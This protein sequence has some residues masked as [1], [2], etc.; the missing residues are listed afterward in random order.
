[1][2]TGS[3]LLFGAFLGGSGAFVALF[4]LDLCGGLLKAAYRKVRSMSA[5]AAF[6]PSAPWLAAH[7]G[8][9]LR[10]AVRDMRRVHRGSWNL[11][12][13]DDPD[14]AALSVDLWL[15]RRADRMAAEV[16]R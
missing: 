14:N 12:D 4:A 16:S 2:S 15:E 5:G 11:P 13:P 3:V 1:M 8:Q 10:E 9:V 7:D 6:T